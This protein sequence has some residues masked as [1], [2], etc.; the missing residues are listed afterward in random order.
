MMSLGWQP[1]AAGLV[2]GLAAIY[3]FWKFFLAGRTKKS[4]QSPDVSLR[5]LR[6]SAKDTGRRTK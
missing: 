3:L 6:R 5:R 2:V 4:P 1:L